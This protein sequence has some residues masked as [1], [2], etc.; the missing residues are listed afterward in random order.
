MCD[1]NK[2]AINGGL[3]IDLLA[4]NTILQDQTI[5]NIENDV[6]GLD[7][8]NLNNNFADINEEECQDVIFEMAENSIA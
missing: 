1:Y 3:D 5:N 2:N 6:S 8:L 7:M 4:D